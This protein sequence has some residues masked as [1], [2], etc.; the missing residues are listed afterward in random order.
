MRNKLI[1]KAQKAS[2]ASTRRYVV[3]APFS[4]IAKRTE[5]AVMGHNNIKDAKSLAAVYR[6]RNWPVAIAR[7]G[8]VLELWI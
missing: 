2:K 3:V 5:Y 4:R 1:A 8:K 7:A 6:E